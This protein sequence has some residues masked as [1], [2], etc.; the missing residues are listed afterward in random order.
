MGGAMGMVM[1]M[2]KPLEVIAEIVGPIA[3]IFDA[4][5]I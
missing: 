4:I 3:A 2:V 1:D 5:D